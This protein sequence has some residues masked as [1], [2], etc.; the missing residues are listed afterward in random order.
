[1]HE[2]RISIF[3][4]ILCFFC[5]NGVEARTLERSDLSWVQVTAVQDGN[6]KQ[7]RVRGCPFS[8]NTGF[9]KPKVTIQ[10]NE[11]WLRNE[12]R[13]IRGEGFDIDIDVPDTV[14][15]L[16]FGNKRIVV[17]PFDEG[18]APRDLHQ[19]KA[20][21]TA[22]TAFRKNSPSVDLDDYHCSVG[23]VM[24]N[25]QRIPVLF[26]ETVSGSKIHTI[27]SY[28]IRTDDFTVDRVYKSSCALSDWKPGEIP[29]NS[30]EISP[31]Q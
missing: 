21:E 29:A 13:A 27:Y 9:S 20:M 8:S 2:K 30:E 17:W 23:H 31:P 6:H 11:A 18:D 26:F 3:L 15:R 24:T 22:K 7:L 14:D 16:V 19:I 25:A 10:G 4:F 12:F 1:M 5:T 28:I